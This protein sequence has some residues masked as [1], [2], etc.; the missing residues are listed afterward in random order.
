MFIPQS[1][2]IVRTAPTKRSKTVVNYESKD[3]M[4]DFAF[5]VAHLGLDK[6]FVA[7]NVKKRDG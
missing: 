7:T 4:R 5:S 3:A 2:V 1:P 6:V